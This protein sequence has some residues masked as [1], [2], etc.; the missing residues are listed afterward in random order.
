[1]SNIE[2]VNDYIYLDLRAENTVVSDTVRIV[3]TIAAMLTPGFTEE[4]LR[5]DIKDALA[6]F[7]PSA[8]WQTN[9]LNRTRDASGYERISLNAAAR[10]SER[11]N[12]NLE[13]RAEAVSRTGL[14]ITNVI[15]DT[16]IQAKKIEEAERALRKDVLIK[17]MEELKIINEVVSDSAYSPFRIGQITFSNHGTSNAKSLNA[18]I[19]SASYG[20][21]LG[22]AGSAGPEG[23]SGASLTNAQKISLSASVQFTRSFIVS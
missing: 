1:M 5:A 20:S 3:T 8:E 21:S 14:K 11:E 23:T 18:T 15:A 4:Q 12:Y 6:K 16:T 19:A 10:V 7:I 2:P 13:E 9:N 17:A 22:V